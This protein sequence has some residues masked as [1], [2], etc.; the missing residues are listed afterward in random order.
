MKI[1]CV[2]L[3]SGFSTRFGCNKLLERV[4]GN[5]L[6]SHALAAFPAPL[7]DRRVVTSRFD[8]IL[9]LGKAK[10]W[11]PLFNRDADEGVSAGIRLGMAAMGGMD[12]VLFAVCDQPWLT[13][14]S[15]ARLVAAFEKQPDR[16]TALGWRGRKGNPVIFP[17][18]LAADLAIL[19]G[20][21]GG[22]A[23]IPKNLRRLIT[24]EAAF[25]KELWDIDTP[26]DLGK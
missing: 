1:G 6:A 22:S 2:L 11:Q 17:R 18:D 20:D 4:E 5:T 15:V 19:T 21:T 10:G 26:E 13:R 8:D 3:A 23:V 24:V 14:E 16:I 7:F 12:G 25:E 9:A